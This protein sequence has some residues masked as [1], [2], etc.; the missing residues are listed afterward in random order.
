MKNYFP[1]GYE[2]WNLLTWYFLWKQAFLFNNFAC[3][4]NL[5]GFNN[6]LFFQCKK[7]T[8]LLTKLLLFFPPGNLHLKWC[9]SGGDSFLCMLTINLKCLIFVS[10]FMYVIAFFSS[11]CFTVTHT[12][13]LKHVATVWS[14]YQGFKTPCLLSEYCCW[15][16]SFFLF[17]TIKNTRTYIHTPLNE[18]L[19]LYAVIEAMRYRAL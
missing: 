15:F 19:T 14:R 10:H 16:M 4:V 3:Y 6:V 7:Y 8:F 11:L 2:T 13:T 12:Y 5:S 9:I 18:G 17:Y 1:I